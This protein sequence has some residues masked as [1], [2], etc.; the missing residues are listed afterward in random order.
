MAVDLPAAQAAA[1]APTPCPAAHPLSDL[2]AARLRK[3]G[4]LRQFNMAEVAQHSSPSDGWVVVAG[5]VSAAPPLPP[6]RAAHRPPR[7]P[8]LGPRC[9]HLHGTVD[10]PPSHH[11]RC[12]H[13]LP[14]PPHTHTHAHTHLST[15]QVYDITEHVRT[16]AGWSSGCATSQLLAILR[17][18]GTDCTEEV[19]MVHSRRALAQFAPFLI[20]VLEEQEAAAAGPQCGGGGSA[21]SS[22]SDLT[23]C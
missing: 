2:I 21:S 14:P 17:T 23:A 11:F 12:L 22:R 19:L 6:A 13:H 9:L 4:R 7:G 3:Q 8:F 20:G 18:L 5:H 15:V 1:Q 10:S 16:H